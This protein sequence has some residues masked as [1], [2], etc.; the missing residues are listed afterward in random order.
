MQEGQHHTI[1]LRCPRRRHGEAEAGA[2]GFVRVYC[3]YC[4]SHPGEVV[5][6]RFD[7]ATGDCETKRVADPRRYVETTGDQ[8]QGAQLG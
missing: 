6:H 2:T 8:A 3:R 4:R 1:T 5:W 7:L